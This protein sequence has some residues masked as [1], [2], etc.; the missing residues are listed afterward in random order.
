MTQV[1]EHI[2]LPIVD[3]C[4]YVLL[5]LTPFE[6]KSS[7]SFRVQCYISGDNQ[8]NYK[9]YQ[10]QT[11]SDPL[12]EVN[13]MLTLY[14]TQCS[15]RAEVNSALDQEIFALKIKL[16]RNFHGVKFLWFA[17]FFNS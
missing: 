5:I 9:T 13:E 16:V 17:K 7:S 12:M 15:K 6:H 4:V 1:C 11:P 8:I 14:P 3:A 2:W 10:S